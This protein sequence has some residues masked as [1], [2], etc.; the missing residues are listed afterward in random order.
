MKIDSGEPAELVTGVHAWRTARSKRVL[1]WL[2]KTCRSTAQTCMRGFYF[3]ANSGND[4]PTARVPHAF[5]GSCGALT[6]RPAEY[7]GVKCEFS[8]FLTCV[9]SKRK[10]LRKNRI[11]AAAV[12]WY[13]CFNEEE[14][15]RNTSFDAAVLGEQRHRDDLVQAD[16]PKHPGSW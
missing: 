4:R 7:K 6:T 10:R 14:N 11:N 1:R 12:Q 5:G 15:D 13:L 16:P 2:K 3:F 9:G 8:S